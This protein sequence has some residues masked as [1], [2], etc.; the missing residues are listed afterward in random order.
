MK[1]TINSSNSF[2]LNVLDE[3]SSVMFIAQINH[4]SATAFM[5]YVKPFITNTIKCEP[6]QGNAGNNL[7]YFQTVN[8]SCID[9]LVFA[10]IMNKGY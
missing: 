3:F 6:G 1:Q 10:E 9:Y 2:S 7:E 4:N 8:G 5:N